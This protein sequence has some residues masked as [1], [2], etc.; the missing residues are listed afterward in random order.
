M[1]K[2]WTKKLHLL[3]V[4]T[5]L[6][7]GLTSAVFALQ[8]SLGQ[9]SDWTATMLHVGGSWV[10]W[11]IIAPLFYVLAQTYPL[12]GSG[13]LRRLPIHIGAALIGLVSAIFVHEWIH[14]RLP[15]AEPPRF[16]VGGHTLHHWRKEDHGIVPGGEWFREKH[17]WDEELAG[18]R[19]GPGMR[20]EGHGKHGHLHEAG[21]SRRQSF[22]VWQNGLLLVAVI[23]ISHALYFSRKSASRA[24]QAAELELS[25]NDARL[26]ALTMQLQP[27]FLFNALNSIAALMHESVERADEMLVALADFLRLVLVAPQGALIP[28][29]DEM[30]YIRQYLAIEKVRFGDR[31]VFEERLSGES[32]NVRIPFLLLQPIVENAFKHAF[33]K[34]ET[35]CQLII[36][37]AREGSSLILRVRD[38]GAGKEAVRAERTGLGN[39]R[40]RL[41]L[42]YGVAASLRIFNEG[43][44]VV[45]IQIPI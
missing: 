1:P 45:E 31:L 23:S 2:R 38:N 27:H 35:S 5:L 40:A 37:S 24:Q 29:D 42:V 12:E 11:P 26:K 9:E 8:L 41:R 7:W 21:F 34:M 44:C 18:R 15:R 6:I 39:T 14:D 28:L 33:Q 43:G 17:R 22:V 20:E 36:E 25:L 3:W 13:W 4:W 19:R 16:E 10:V 32:L 30:R